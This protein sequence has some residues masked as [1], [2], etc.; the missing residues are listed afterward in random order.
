MKK[1]MLR[2]T[3]GTYILTID[4]ETLTHDPV[5]LERDGRPVAVILP[6]AEYE[7]L[8][9]RYKY[10]QLQQEFDARLNKLEER[11]AYLEARVAALEEKLRRLLTQPERFTFR[12][13]AIAG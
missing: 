6:I 1:S 5:V 8:R 3:L 4:K 12:D 11:Q 7:A 13:V 10:K 2:E 9:G